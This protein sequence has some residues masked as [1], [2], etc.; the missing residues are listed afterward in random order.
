MPS[1]HIKG[2]I[3]YGE[4]LEAV[5]KNLPS[6]WEPR[7]HWYREDVEVKGARS[8]K[9]KLS[10]ADIGKRIKAS[11]EFVSEDSDGSL[12]PYRFYTQQTE[13]IGWDPVT[14][15]LVGAP[16][17]DSSIYVVTDNLPGPEWILETVWYRDGNEVLDY[18]D[19]L[20]YK[21]GP[22]D[23]GKKI[24]V[25]VVYRDGREVVADLFSKSQMEVVF[26]PSPPSLKGTPRYDSVLR[27]APQHYPDTWTREL[28][29]Y[30][31]LD[32]GQTYDTIKSSDGIENLKLSFTEIG[33]KIRAGVRFRVP[34]TNQFN[35]KVYNY[36]E[37]LFSGWADPVK[38]FEIPKPVLKGNAKV[39]SLLK[40]SSIYS[41]AG[42][43][44][45]IRWYRGYPD[46]YAVIPGEDKLYYE[47]KPADTGQTIRVGISLVHQSGISLP[48]E[49]S[50]PTSYVPWKEPTPVL[51]GSPTLYSTL[52]VKNISTP[53]KGWQVKANWYRKIANHLELIPLPE[54]AMQYTLSMQ[55]VN[56]EIGVL[57]FYVRQNPYMATNGVRSAYSM[58]KVIS[59]K[60]QIV[61]KDNGKYECG[62]V[63]KAMIGNDEAPKQGWEFIWYRDTA[64]TLGKYQILGQTKA[65]YQLLK[66]DVGKRIQVELFSKDV[67]VIQQDFRVSSF[68]DPISQC[69]DLSPNPVPSSLQ[70]QGDPVVGGT[71]RAEV[72]NPSTPSGWQLRY[73]WYADG[74]KISGQT[75][76]QY[77]LSVLSLGENISFG[78]YFLKPDGSHTEDIK[79]SESVHIF[80]DPGMT[81]EGVTK[82]GTFLKLNIGIPSD[83]KLP[84]GWTSKVEWYEGTR[85]SKNGFGTKG[86]YYL[87]N[88]D[89][90][91]TPIFARHYFINP[92]GK[93]KFT[94]ESKKLYAKVTKGDLIK[95]SFTRLNRV[96]RA[97]MSINSDMLSGTA[98]QPPGVTR[99]LFWERVH[100]T[101]NNKE[102]IARADQLNYDMQDKDQGLFI[103]GGIRLKLDGKEI[104]KENSDRIGPIYEP[105]GKVTIP[106]IS[107]THT[108]ILHTPYTASLS[109]SL[110]IPKGVR[111]EYNWY[112]G[113]NTWV[114]LSKSPSP[115]YTPQLSDVGYS[116]I[117]RAKFYA[118]KYSSDL[119]PPS[120]PSHKISLSRPVLSHDDNISYLGQ[121]ITASVPG[122]SDAL[123]QQHLR[124]QW[125]RDDEKI[126]GITDSSR[127]HCVVE[128][129]G[130]EITVRVSP[131]S[132]GHWTSSSPTSVA[133]K[134][135][136][137]DGFDYD[138]D[139]KI[140]WHKYTG[141]RIL[142]YYG[143][144]VLSNFI[145][146]GFTA[147]F[148]YNKY[149]YYFGPPGSRYIRSGSSSIPH[150]NND[151]DYYKLRI[152]VRY[153]SKTSSKTT[154][155]SDWKEYGLKTWGKRI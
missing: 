8:N 76:S 23:F 43:D 98:H 100:P 132:I 127:H 61:V 116:I 16:K 149:H 58:V 88:Y 90:Y 36:T 11:L 56:N 110:N 103:Q 144:A 77:S 50:Q 141:T 129:M 63:L 42:W 60:V 41:P 67:G 114:M 96:R 53:P 48:E 1:V 117:A 75:G 151:S 147:E 17:L 85:K 106:K 12:T 122:V 51:E 35:D 118:Q 112:R 150:E 9:Y 30:K 91:H 32:D 153:K 47:V 128:D 73:N 137:P 87:I 15:S 44:T 27:V 83:Y 38:F 68:T 139:P 145:P 146:V 125:Y 138:K 95:L 22:E 37:E 131:K 94:K 109:S 99:E 71:L 21:V 2:V 126:G 140:T 74:V 124:Y 24:R 52:K 135:K 39:Y 148:E 143:R 134:P 46:D 79:V 69:K 65:E 7:L 80:P 57:V 119:S 136:P 59:E 152:R 154:P 133:D 101:S 104:F 86:Y 78:Y 13:P 19:S 130:K 72:G 105:I 66:R 142:T 20:R 97:S 70:I 28:R 92:E 108:G 121:V 113:P 33:Y 54:D 81:V 107:S 34:H 4:T 49:F 82:L 62:Q 6:G 102:I 25:R 64:S 18:R 111:V 29:W 3:K 93:K 14:P 84:T 155:W 55:D 31:T 115:T 123:A 26:K 10:Q 45:R 120:S 40:V 89:S 5:L